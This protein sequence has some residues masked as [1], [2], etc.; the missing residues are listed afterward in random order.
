MQ[1]RN[2]VDDQDD[3]QPTQGL[4]CPELESDACGTGLIA[5]LSG[6]PTH[7]VV[8]D[9]LTMLV[10]M[11]HRG[12]CGCEPNSGDGAGILVQ[13]PHDFLVDKCR[14]SGFDLPAFGEYGVGMVFFPADRTLSEQCRF[15]FDDYVDELGLELLGYRKVPIDN[16]EV[17]P[18]SRSVEPRMEQVF[19][20]PKTSMDPQAL[21]RRLYVLR[22][23]ATHNIHQTYPLTQD[24]FYVA[25]F[26]YKTIVYK[27][28]L[29]TWQLRPYFPDLQDS[30]FKSRVA[31]VHSRFST[32]TEPKW[33]LAQPFRMIAHNGEINTVRGNLNWWKSKESLLKSSLFTEEEMERLYPICGEHLSDSG[34]FDN[35]LEFLVLNGFSLPHALMMMIPEAWQHD[36]KMPDYKKSFYEYHKTLMEP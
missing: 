27:G 29:T 8:R 26:S 32:N 30:R 5:N 33:K 11:E 16:E 6:E 9:A 25:S 34:N 4:Y 10:N 14:E 36:D 21:E 13:L 24:H 15:L 17:G 7:E 18:T 1:E 2:I 22:K 19:V 28:Q 12:A 31:L 23:Y 20:K 3:Q 35:V